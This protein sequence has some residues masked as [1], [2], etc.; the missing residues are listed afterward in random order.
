VTETFW[1]AFAVLFGLDMVI[2]MVRASI[3]NARL[4]LLLTLRAQ[5]ESGVDR[6][7]RLLERPRLRSSLRLG[8]VMVRFMLLG[9]IIWLFLLLAGGPPSFGLSLI[10][11]AAAGLVL[12]VI[13]FLLEG[14]ILPHA[15]LWAVRFSWLAQAID[16]L[17]SPISSLLVLLLG[18]PDMLGH[19]LN[20]VTED[21]LK[22]WVEEGGESVGSLEQGERRMI[23]SIFHFGDTLAREI[24]VPRIDILSLDVTTPFDEAIVALN[25]TGHS[26]VPVYED[27]IDNIIGLLYAKD[28]LRVRTEGQSI[29]SLRSLLRP[30]YFVPEAKK[31]DELLRE[32]QARSIH[33]AIVVDEYGGI[34]GLVTLEDI[35]EEIVGEIR[36][37]YDVSEEQLFERVSDNEYLFHGR[38]DL[39]DF[40]QVMSTRL[41]KDAADTLG[42]FIYSQIGRVPVGGEQIQVDNMVLTVEQVSGRR[43]RRV[44][45][46]ARST[47]PEMEEKANDDEAGG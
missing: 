36:D 26:R 6:T 14:L 33:M 39:D 17:L 34:A 41:P 21:E 2:A 45:A 40:N 24:M 16:F 22:S 43:I 10:L 28:L 5:Y 11:L 15:E 31:V 42:G 3:L 37:E 25:R 38:I 23:Y 30:A 32:M 1:I 8:V 27:T 7:V 20:P 19:R 9:M 13:E 29:S 18:S 35:V 4:P 44:R 46:A 12:L 47:I